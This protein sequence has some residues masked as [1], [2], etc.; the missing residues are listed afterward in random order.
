MDP[1]TLIPQ[2]YAQPGVPVALLAPLVPLPLV[3]LARGLAG[4]RSGRGETRTP[5]AGPGVGP[6]ADP[7]PPALEPQLPE[8]EL[9][10]KCGPDSAAGSGPCAGEDGAT[11]QMSSGINT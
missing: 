3:P 4:A 1:D 9:G 2:L 11:G 8:K 7:V 6:A 5:S 10:L